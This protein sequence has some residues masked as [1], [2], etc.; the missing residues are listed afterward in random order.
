[1]AWEVIK[2]TDGIKQL[3]LDEVKVSENILGIC[4]FW[5]IPAL[6]GACF[7]NIFD[8]RLDDVSTF[9]FKLSGSIEEPIIERLIVW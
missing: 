1:M 5:G 3:S 8:E 6:A 9:K 7:E 2:D 4:N